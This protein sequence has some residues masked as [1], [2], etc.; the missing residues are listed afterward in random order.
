MCYSPQHE[1]DC[2]G[3]RVIVNALRALIFAVLCAQVV[4]VGADSTDVNQRGA[5]VYL[6][7]CALC[8]G[9]KGLGEGPMALLIHDYPDTRLNKGNSSGHVVRGIVENGSDP[10]NGTALSPPWRDELPASDIEAVTKFIDV[11]R[12]DF[13]YATKLLSSAV[14][15][16]GRFDGRKIFRARCET[17]HGRTGKGDGRMSRIIR[18]PPPADLTR[19]TLSRDETIAMVSSGG[20]SQ[21]RSEQM[22]PWGQELFYAELLSVVEYLES[23]RTTQAELSD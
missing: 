18:N 12:N 8:H 23:I 9:S 13:D 11:L 4:Y 16:P 5:Q 1:N 10:E 20:K 15:A 14:V 7:R 3:G 22:P 2:R 21:G 19:S 17:C 6:E